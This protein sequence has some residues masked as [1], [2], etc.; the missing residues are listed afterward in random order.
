MIKTCI[1]IRDIRYSCLILMKLEFSRQTF[2]KHW[3]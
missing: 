1:N 2:E 3:Y